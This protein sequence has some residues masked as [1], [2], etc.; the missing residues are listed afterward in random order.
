MWIIA[1]KDKMKFRWTYAISMRTSG[2]QRNHRGKS[3]RFI[4]ANIAKYYNKR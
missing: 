2:L 4:F 3:S 1:L